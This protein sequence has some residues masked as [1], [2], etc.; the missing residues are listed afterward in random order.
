MSPKRTVARPSGVTV[1]PGVA[2]GTEKAAP[3]R[4]ERRQQRRIDTEAR[5]LANV[6]AI[7]AKQGVE[8][9]G[10]NAVA[11]AAGVDKALIYR[12]FGDWDGLLRAYGRSA[13]FWP[14]LEEVLGPDAA[15]LRA[16]TLGAVAGQIVVNFARALRRRPAT[17]AL[18]RWECAHRN[19]LT[20]ILE[21]AREAWSRQL[22]E[23]VRRVWPNVDPMVSGLT[24]LL[25]AALSYFAV[26]GGEVKTFAGLDIRSPEGWNV[27][28]GLVTMAL[29]RVAGEPGKGA[30]RRKD[31]VGS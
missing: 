9:L 30:S 4:A 21:E 29:A 13:D 27:L 12:Y 22:E 7:L 11:A 15:V 6:G 23:E 8:G 28:E 16:H 1:L 5:L 10:V 25:S 17:L 14:P 3:E 31:T 19:P 26:R 20:Q 2:R 24:V 18:M